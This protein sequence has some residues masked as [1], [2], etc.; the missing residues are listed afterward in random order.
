MAASAAGAIDRTGA[1]FGAGTSLLVASLCLAAFRLRRPST[2]L[3][4]RTRLGRGRRASASATPPSGRA[5]ACSRSASS[6]PRRSSSSPSMRF[7]RRRRRRPIATPASA[8]IRCSSTC[9]C[10]SPHDP[11]SREGRDALG[12]GDAAPDQ[13]TIEPFRVRPR[14]RCE[15][16]EPV[17]AAEIRASSASRRSFIDGGPVRVPEL[18]RGDRRR[19]RQSLA[20]AEPR[21]R[22]RRRRGAGDRRRELDDLRPPQSAR[23]RH[24]RR[25]RRAAAPA[26]PGGGAR[27]QH[28]PGRAADVG[29]ATSSA[30][31]PSRR[32]TGSC[33]S[34][35]RPE[36]AAAVAAAIEQDAGDLGADAVLD[37]RAAGGVSRGREHVPLDVQDARRPRAAGRHHRARRGAAA[38][39]ARAAPRAGAARRD[40]LS[41][42]PHLRDRPRRE[43]AAARLGSRG[44]RA[45][46]PPWRL[47]RSCSSAAGGCRRRPAPG[48]C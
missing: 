26:A 29:R 25:S 34:R 41:P 8:A 38:Q 9:C 43:R 39:R 14:R 28:L 3:H 48:C 46:A 15:L 17:R 42:R 24:R 6:R 40:R 22:R 20:A 19:A 7:T 16:P 45:A 1:F 33:W 12:L 11:N 35:R 31:F 10:R 21:D 4:R 13:I 36:R 30:C 2:T 5:A 32:A 47:R 44:R 18:A 23:R 27:R 37:G